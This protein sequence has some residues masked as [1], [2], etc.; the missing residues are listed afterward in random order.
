[1]SVA[2][3]TRSLSMNYRVGGNFFRGGAP[4]LVH[5]LRGVDLEVPQGEIFGLVGRNGY[6]KTTLIKCVA[7]LLHPTRGSVAVFGHDTVRS[8]RSLRRR[9][10]WVGTEERSFYYRL[11]GLQNLMF[12]GRL[13][14]IPGAET[15]NRVHRL[16]AQFETEALLGRRFHEYSTGNRQRLAILRALLHDPDLLILDEP[17]R[18]LDPFAADILRRA[19]K[20]WTCERAIRTIVI[21]SHNLD[22]V[23]ALSDT[24][25]IMSRGALRV[26]GRVEALRCRFGSRETVSLNLADPVAQTLLQ[27]LQEEVD[28]L[29]WEPAATN[30]G[31]AGWLRVPQRPGDGS[32]DRTLR[33]LLH[34]SAKIV[35]IARQVLT[36]QDI[37]DRVDE[38]QPTD[39]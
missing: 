1:M 3:R 24:V 33:A 8:A 25:G 2:I 14:G 5:A 13:Q 38:A 10:G 19:L 31:T 18:S 39:A 21:T 22:E 7:S 20:T 4:R 17:T 35:T 32:L 6:G 34:D 29:H 16:A 27:E 36:L 26:C 23:E 11:T 30:D 15:R 37:I 28:G 12:F 9:I